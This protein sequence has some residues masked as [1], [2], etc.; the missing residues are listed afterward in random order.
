MHLEASLLR[1]LEP[2]L[3]DQPGEIA[4]QQSLER[5]TYDPATRQVSVS[6]RDGSRFAYSLPAKPER[7]S[8]EGRV[9]AVSRTMALAICY[10]E[11]ARERKLCSYE[12]LAKLGQ[13]TRS[14]VSL[15]LLLT[16]L[17]PAI[18]EEL[19]LLPKVISGPERI[20][21]EQLRSIAKLIDWDEQIAR[22]RS[23]WD[24]SSP[25]SKRDGHSRA[26]A[27]PSGVDSVLRASNGTHVPRPSGMTALSVPVSAGC[28]R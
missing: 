6:L 18:Q 22:F 24:S 5:I 10:Q 17:A 2:I 11:L 4:I 13:L 23:L 16:N 19:L 21:E 26:N 1:E 15:M 3:G 25:T 14:R 8:R 20:S 27:W 7:P 9:P 28:A 12:E